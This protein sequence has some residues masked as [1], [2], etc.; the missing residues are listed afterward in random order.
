MF[1]VQYSLC[2]RVNIAPREPLPIQRG[3]IVI[4]SISFSVVTTRE[5]KTKRKD[6]RK[7]KTRRKTKREKD[8]VEDK[9]EDEEEDKIEEEEEDEEEELKMPEL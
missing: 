6:E 3:V 4:S 7:R 5:V 9:E 2:N 8:E 1:S